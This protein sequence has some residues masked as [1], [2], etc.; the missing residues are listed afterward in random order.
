M[1]LG[2]VSAT[3][4]AVAARLDD[5]FLLPVT[6]RVPSKGR[7]W[8]NSAWARGLVTHA[9]YEDTAT[10]TGR[11][12]RTHGLVIG[13]DAATKAHLLAGVYAA[14]TASELRSDNGLSIDAAQQ[15][16]GLYAALRFGSFFADA[17]LSAGKADADAFRDE[18]AGRTR[19]TYKNTHLG[20][21][22][23]AGFIINAWKDAQIKA[24]AG[25]RYTKIKINDYAEDG[26]GAMLVPDFS[27]KLVQGVARIQADQKF[28]LLG[29]PAAA[30][31]ALGW[32]QALRSPRKR[33]DAAFAA[34]PSAVFTLEGDDLYNKGSAQTLG[35]SL[36]VA[37]TRATVLSLDCERETA[38][39]LTRNTASLT[40][41]CAW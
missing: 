10:Q 25:A 23:G 22:L 38:P 13:L 5:Q 34:D 27:D 12:D 16:A 32:K 41:G 11:T 7:S 15:L 14:L 6:P 35:L 39:D 9:S 3:L 29:R 26:P 28:K 19:G 17:G 20:G 40:L 4:D 21:S 37:L 31:L 24:S 8:S 33:M 18:P 36:R 1:T 2:T 30:G